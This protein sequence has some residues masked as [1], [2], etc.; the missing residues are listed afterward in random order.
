MFVLCIAIQTMATQGAGATIVAAVQMQAEKFAQKLAQ[1]N[2][3]YDPDKCRQLLTE[4][5]KCDDRDDWAECQKLARDKIR[6]SYDWTRDK[7]LFTEF[8]SESSNDSELT[9]RI[10]SSR[11]AEAGSFQGTR[12]ALVIGNGAYPSGPLSSPEKDEQAV[13][14]KLEVLGFSVAERRDLNREGMLEAIREFSEQLKEH[15]NAVALFYYSG[16]G[17][18]VNGRNYLIPIDANIRREEDAEDYAVPLENVLAR[19][20]STQDEANIIVLDACRD[21]SY[22][23][24]WKSSNKGLAPITDRPPRTLIAYAAAP[25]HVALEG[26]EGNLSK[27]TEALV[28]RIDEPNVNLLTMFQNVLNSVDES[29]RGQQ[30]PSLEISPGLPNLSLV[31]VG[32]ARAPS[33]PSLSGRQKSGEEAE[34]LMDEALKRFGNGN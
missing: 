7:N 24:R 13:A 31:P 27:Y 26:S 4:Y 19:M 30:E 33:P 32:T 8:G 21:N 6:S 15:P 29:T 17:M 20:T 9:G 25:G 23:K 2:S 10:A 12:L 3:S 11:A 1:C 18:S 34:K 14:A 16:H 28:A 5:R 22:E